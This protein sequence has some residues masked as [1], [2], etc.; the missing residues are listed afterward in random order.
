MQTSLHAANC[1]LY[2]YNFL[3][4]HIL[5]CRNRGLGLRVNTLSHGQRDCNFT[6][7]LRIQLFSSKTFPVGVEVAP[8][9]TDQTYFL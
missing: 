1:I 2:R 9:W 5:C 8:K 4:D 7:I 6:Y 3:Y